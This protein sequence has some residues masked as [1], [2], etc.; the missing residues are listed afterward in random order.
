MSVGFEVGSK[1]ERATCRV[2]ATTRNNRGLLK[3]KQL[4]AELLQLSNC[5][6][7]STAAFKNFFKND[8]K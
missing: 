1:V 4:P 6:K 5:S 3:N 7:A 2:A 8:L